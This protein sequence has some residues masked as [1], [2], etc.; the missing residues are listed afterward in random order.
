MTTRGRFPARLPLWARYCCPATTWHIDGYRVR[1]VLAVLLMRCQNACWVF[2]EEPGRID[3]RRLTDG[4]L[5][6]VIPLVYGT[7]VD[8]S[9][10]GLHNTGSIF[11]KVQKHWQKEQI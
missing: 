4:R 8:T 9:E 1:G 7:V 11:P 10:E 6:P 2:A 3:Q 5:H